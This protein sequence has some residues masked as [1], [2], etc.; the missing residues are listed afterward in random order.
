[1]ND[2]NNTSG[3]VGS[4]LQAMVALNLHGPS[5]VAHGNTALATRATYTMLVIVALA[6]LV[7]IALGL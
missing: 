2:P 4:V 3:N 7:L 1:M 6:V 5:D